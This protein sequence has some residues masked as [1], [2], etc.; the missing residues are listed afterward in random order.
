MKEPEFFILQRAIGRTEWI[1][2]KEEGILCC[3]YS[4]KGCKKRLSN[5]SHGCRMTLE[6]LWFMARVVLLKTERY[7][8]GT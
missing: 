7:L 6:I 2:G 1:S 3:C 5:E 8:R 4:R